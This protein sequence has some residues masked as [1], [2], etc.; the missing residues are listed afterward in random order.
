MLSSRCFHSAFADAARQVNA[1]ERAMPPTNN[2]SGNRVESLMMPGFVAARPSDATPIDDEVP[3]NSATVSIVVLSMGVVYAIGS[4]GW[5]VA[6]SP[7]RFSQRD[8]VP[9]HCEKIAEDSSRII[10]G[11]TLM[12]TR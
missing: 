6:F 1:A 4:T 10:G 2:E 11:G 8:A 9:N 7:V 12:P 5:R 3:T